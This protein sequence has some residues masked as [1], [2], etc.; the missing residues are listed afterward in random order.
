MITKALL[1]KVIDGTRDERMY[2]CSKD[3]A[4]F[5][6]Y[7]FVDYIKYPF[8]QFHYEMFEDLNDLLNGNIK[9]LAWVGFRECAKTAITKGFLAYIICYKRRMYPNWD[10]FDKENAERALFDTVTELQTNL[11]LRADF[12]ELFNA[13]RNPDEVQQKRVTN[14]VTN[15][16]VRV[17][18]HST[19]QSMRGRLHRNNRPDVL[20]LDDFE[21]IS[22]KDSKPETE[23]VWGH[24]EEAM[25][26]LDS[27]GFIIYLC[28]Y[29]TEH[30][31]VYKIIE[32]AKTDPSLRVR[33]INV[34]NPLG[35]PTWPAK[36]C[37]T[38]AESK[39]TGKVS[40]EAKKR[41]FGSIVFSAEMMN[42][43]IDSV[44][45]KFK[46]SMFKYRTWAEVER[47]S[48]RKFATIDT[49][50]SKDAHSDF[51]GLV[52]NYVDRENKWNLVG[53]QMRI[54]PGEVINLI[55][56]LH[57]EGFEKIGI[58]K[59]V[60]L[61]VLRPFFDEECRKRNKY[62]RIVE[63]KHGGIMK[64]SRIEVLVAYYEAG[65]IFHIEGECEE[66]EL[67]LLKFPNGLHDDIIDAEQYQSHIAEPPYTQSV[68][69]V[70]ARAR[71]IR[72][73]TSTQSR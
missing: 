51:L 27:S 7:Y 5:F 46:K 28:N 29:I 48:T 56:Q 18:A 60:Y 6:C 39:E 26:G 31:N 52:K 12:G 8:A 2:L 33:I 50:M 20:I 25:T 1:Q 37:L 71:E 54:S 9:E 17:E 58:E 69:Q 68:E 14:F 13:S 55:F 23:Q 43:P 63:L 30:G 3:F 61:D 72:R 22:T 53:K 38:D 4:L 73:N 40:I 35:Q 36:Y 47:L 16:K 49:A 21:T 70:A 15:N 64:E 24:I 65:S 34:L 62:P 11:R 42:E 59:T 10:C 41:Q 19:G 44:S 57:E 67:Q 32:R 45:Q 66:M